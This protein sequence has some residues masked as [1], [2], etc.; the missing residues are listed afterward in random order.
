MRAAVY[1]G[2]GRLEVQQIPVPEIGPGEL[3]VKVHACGICHTDLKKVE[4]DLLPPPRVYGHETAGEVVKVGAG[5]EKFKVGD[6]VVAFHHI[7]CRNCFYCDRK[8]YAQCAGYKK[9][10]ITA[11]FEPA[12]GGFSQYIRIMDWIVRDGVLLIPDGV[13]YE[14]ASFVEPVN[15]CHKAVVEM[16]PQPGDT[17]LIQGQGP[18]GLIF[19]MLVK[20]SG[21]RIIATDTMEE[22]LALARRFGATE[23]VDPRTTD[24]VAL[25][26]PMTEGR[27]V[28]QVFV[29][30]S[31]PG[32]V[33]EALRASR[34]G[35]KILLFAQTSDTERIELSGAGICKD[36][37][38]L[39]GVYSASVDLQAESAR[40]VLEGELPV[41]DLVSHSLGL[42][43]INEG[44]RMALHPDGKSLKIM[45]QPQRTS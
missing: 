44:I 38:S 2:N 26:K 33:E 42:D 9:V 8:L 23:A 41:A 43:K 31:A 21:A 6:R 4:H 14:V 10:G 40:L 29:A 11:G 17:V 18:I 45:V 7:P 13:S 25:V 39:I 28:D 24:V 1:T 36:E 35:A 19:T 22:R 12:G 5:V 37:R 27:G 34:P 32:I 15:T 16:D 3:L 30:A 20:R